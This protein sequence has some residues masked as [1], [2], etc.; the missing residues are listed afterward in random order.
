MMTYSGGSTFSN[1]L[2]SS[3]TSLAPVTSPT[4]AHIQMQAPELASASRLEGVGVPGVCS[5]AGTAMTE[6]LGGPKQSRSSCLSGVYSLPALP[7]TTSRSSATIGGLSKGGGKDAVETNRQTKS[8]VESTISQAF[9]NALST[10]GTFPAKTTQRTTRQEEFIR[11]CDISSQHRQSPLR[12]MNLSSTLMPHSPSPSWMLADLERFTPCLP[13]QREVQTIRA[14]KPSIT[15]SS[16]GVN[17]SATSRQ[18]GNQRTRWDAPLSLPMTTNTRPGAYRSNLTP[19]LSPLRPHCLARER[20]RL[21]KPVISRTANDTQGKHL[22]LSEADLTR[23]M[24]VMAHAWTES[25]HETYGTGLLIFHVFCDRK[26]I[27]EPQ[28]APASSM[29][30]QSFVAS[31]AGSYAGGTISNYLCG[32]HAWHI[33]HGVPLQLNELEMETLLAAATK[34]TPASSKRPKRRPFTPDYITKLKGQLKLDEPL[35]AAVFACLTTCFYAS[36]RVGEF[37]VRRINGFDPTI[38]IKLSDLQE[39]RDRNGLP[40]TNLHIPRTKSSASGET[41]S[42]SRQEGPTDPETALANHCRVNAP[43]VDKHLFS[44]KVNSSLR[45][46]TKTK[47]IER[48]AKAARAAGEDP[49]QGHGIRIGST[50]EYLLR[51]VPFEVMKVQGRWAS[52]AFLLYLRKHGQILAPY[53]QAVPALHQELIHFT[54]PPVR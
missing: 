34:V 7:V 10:H 25:T 42:W 45:P 18:P 31:I 51:G 43:P 54:M 52:D 2:C 35:D 23:V 21:W 11:P 13:N 19:L 33:L 49:L 24:D 48:L 29:L 20:L 37:T 44:Y 26:G 28:R 1:P 47:F 39:E 53:L 38:H 27:P 40:I 6:T 17:I 9:I 4:M 15:V 5:R 8:S 12:S 36:A 30:L 3:A 16:G 41:V 22:S 32:I 46:L 50:L 14:G